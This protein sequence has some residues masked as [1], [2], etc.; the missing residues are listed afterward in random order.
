M[1]VE[2]DREL[3]GRHGD[4][5][6]E[7]WWLTLEGQ[8]ITDLD[9]ASVTAL[10]FGP[11][12]ITHDDLVLQPRRWTQAQSEWAS[13]LLPA[14]PPGPVLELCAGAG[15]IGL[16]AVHGTG[17]S[18]VAVDADPQACRWARHNAAVNA[19]DAEIRM[20]DIELV[21]QEHEQFPLIIADPPW[22]RE[23]DLSRYPDDPGL[24]ID[25]GPDGLAVARRCLQVIAKH[26]HPEGRALLQLGSTQQIE[27][28]ESDLSAVNLTVED[29]HMIAD[30][31]A[32]VLLRHRA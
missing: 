24:A 29:E 7:G 27:E 21:V 19:I 26:L 25:G 16:L 15:Q 3:S 6:D 8:P 5:H 31:G 12:T 13:R 23:E 4:S 11:L 32:L 2:S 30:R 17:R 14:L 22:V 1:R 9:E 28:L 10:A 20:G 18:L